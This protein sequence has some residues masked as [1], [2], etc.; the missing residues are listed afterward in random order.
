MFS[1]PFEGLCPV[2]P[3][4]G[5]RDDRV[6]ETAGRVKLESTPRSDDGAVFLPQP[7][8]GFRMSG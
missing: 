1:L 2:Q 3:S 5:I 7:S 8:V 4:Q 6:G